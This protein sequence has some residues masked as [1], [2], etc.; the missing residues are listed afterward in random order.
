MNK[1][2]IIFLDIDGVLYTSDY[3]KSLVLG[4]RKYRDKYG[5][6]FDPECIKNFNDIIEETGAKV[7]ISSTWRSAG[8]EI[9]KDLFKHRGI[10]GDIIGLTP[11]STIDDLFFNRGEEI[12]YW[13]SRNGLP[14]KFAVLDD[15]SLGDGYDQWAGF[16]QTKM[17]NGITE[18][19]KNKT[20]NYLN[21]N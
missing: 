3:Y 5:F 17:S 11:I 21:D 15:C 10:K 8:I 19:I 18:E 12:E 20:I 16:I 6:L 1:I 9:M 2:K 4:N 7:V 14:N 13:L